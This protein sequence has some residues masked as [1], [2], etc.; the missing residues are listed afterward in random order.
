M[1]ALLPTKDKW[2]DTECGRFKIG[3]VERR[4]GTIIKQIS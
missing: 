2:W 1:F 3:D 4:D